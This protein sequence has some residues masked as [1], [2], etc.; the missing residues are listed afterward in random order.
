MDFRYTART[1]AGAVVRG[2]LSAADVESAVAGLRRRALFVTAVEPKRAWNRE[3][4]QPQF[5]A[6][7]SRARVAFFR[8]FA[9]LVRAGVPIRRGLTVAI[10][11]CENAAA[12]TRLRA[13]YRGH[14][15]GR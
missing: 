6:G 1:A 9:T 13:A 10:E 14:G 15:R 11:R 3:I 8:S 4:R 7:S 2:Q 5:S 12:P